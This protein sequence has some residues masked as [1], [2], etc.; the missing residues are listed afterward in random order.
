MNRRGFLGTILATC[1]LYGGGSEAVT[2]LVSRPTLGKGWI[3]REA[4]DSIGLD[5]AAQWSLVDQMCDTSLDGH[6]IHLFQV[7]AKPGLP[8]RSI[9]RRVWRLDGS[10]ERAHL[11][12]RPEA[13]ALIEAFPEYQTIAAHQF[14][15]LHRQLAPVGSACRLETPARI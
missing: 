9:E 11:E 8:S 7:W 15:V 4:I 12:L 14:E 2:R 13:L 6:E 1:A 10:V 5:G 3:E